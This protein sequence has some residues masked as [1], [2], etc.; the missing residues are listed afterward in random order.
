MLWLDFWGATV[1][2]AVHNQA[3]FTHIA[4][5]FGDHLSQTV[6]FP[7]VSVEFR[8]RERSFF[9]SEPDEREIHLIE[10]GT[11]REWTIEGDDTMNAPTPIPPLALLPLR[12]RVRTIHGAAAVHPT[13]P[14]RAVVLHGPSTAGKS[15]LLLA[16]L[17]RSWAFMSDDIIPVS[18]EN[19][20]LR[21][22]RPIGLR[23]NSAEILGLATSSF[24]EAPRFATPTGITRAVHPRA[25]GLSLGP[26]SSDWTWTVTLVPTNETF[27]AK[28][29]LSRHLHLCLNIDRDLDRAVKAIEELANGT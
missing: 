27:R 4:Y 20:I 29:T 1:R 21:F 19:R 28:R 17:R 23:A 12:S 24:P 22:T 15:T 13:D 5:Y 10:H 8:S 25:L 11:G 18:E 2:V 6:A 9:Q 7:D 3:D 26:M 14:Q 16:L